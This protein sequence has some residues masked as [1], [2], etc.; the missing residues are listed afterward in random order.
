MSDLDDLLRFSRFVET[1]LQTAC[2]G[3]NGDGRE[4]LT[5]CRCCGALMPT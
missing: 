3:D 2:A 4:R 1:T 5:A